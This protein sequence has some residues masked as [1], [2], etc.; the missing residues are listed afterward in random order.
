MRGKAALLGRAVCGDRLMGC[1][2]ARLL[3]FVAVCVRAVAPFCPPAWHNTLDRRE[4]R[5]CAHRPG[6]G[7]PRLRPTRRRAEQRWGV[8]AALDGTVPD[9]EAGGRGAPAFDAWSAAVY[10][11]RD[12]GSMADDSTVT[13]QRLAA[14][15][16]EEGASIEAREEAKASRKRR[17]FRPRRLPASKIP[18]YGPVTVVE[19]SSLE[20][21]AS[22]IWFHDSPPG[23]SSAPRRWEKRLRALKLGWC[24]IVIPSG[25]QS[26]RP[27]STLNKLV[28]R[29]EQ[30]LWFE[31][32]SDHGL[33]SSLQYLQALVAREV[34]SGIPPDRIILAGVGQGGSIAVLGG[35]L[36]NARLGGV[37]AVAAHLPETVALT[38]TPESASTPIL[39]WVPPQDLDAAE[40]A[41]TLM[42]LPGARAGE[43]RRIERAPLPANWLVETV[44]KLRRRWRV[45]G[46]A[47]RAEVCRLRDV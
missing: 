22:V 25:F 44:D 37:V 34:K 27:R 45:W 15:I 28:R 35:L 12:I 38:P 3:V 13:L 47:C 46:S 26:S 24:R 19:P 33:A 2:A 29:G 23:S 36:L 8:S 18:Q 41:D 17:L 16:Q 42:A 6:R 10:G 9:D 14:A 21:T 31:E 32:D 1:R 30:R 7:A 20:H 5:A 4:V 11:G 40:A 39:C 43:R